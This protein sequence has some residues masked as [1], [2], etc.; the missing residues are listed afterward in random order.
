MNELL[1]EI[2][3]ELS[4]CA[5]FDLIVEEIYTLNIFENNTNLKKINYYFQ[6]HR[7]VCLMSKM[8]LKISK[9]SL[10][11]STCTQIIVN[12]LTQNLTR[13]TRK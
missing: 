5:L 2:A 6:L 3:M 9:Y 13:I 12:I 10:I 11:T 4:R 1:S 8:R 7:N